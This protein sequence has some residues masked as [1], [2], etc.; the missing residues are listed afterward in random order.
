MSA[1][2][3]DEGKINTRSAGSTSAM[4]LLLCVHSLL[5]RFDAMFHYSD[6]GV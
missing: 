3:A 4:S 6:E 5:D 1:Q 2:A